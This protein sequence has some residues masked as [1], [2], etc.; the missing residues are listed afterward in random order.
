MLIYVPLGGV[1]MESREFRGN[2]FLET[3][4]QLAKNMVFRHFLL[5][6]ID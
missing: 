6:H 4:H 2:P 5:F 3:D 1:E